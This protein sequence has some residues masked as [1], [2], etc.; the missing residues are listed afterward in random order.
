MEDHSRPIFEPR[1]EIV[2]R[3]SDGQEEV[4]F[5]DQTRAV[6]ALLRQASEELV[7]A[8]KPKKAQERPIQVPNIGNTAGTA[9]FL[10]AIA[11]GSYEKDVFPSPRS[12]FS[13]V[14]LD[15]SGNT[16]RLQSGIP[17]PRLGSESVIDT[18]R[19]VAG[20]PR[21]QDSFEMLSPR[22]AEIEMPPPNKVVRG[23]GG[24]RKKS[25]VIKEKSVPDDELAIVPVPS[26]AVN[27][28]SDTIDG[29]EN[30]N[31]SPRPSPFRDTKPIGDEDP[32]ANS[33]EHYKI[34]SASA[35][36]ARRAIS[37]TGPS[38]DI[39]RQRNTMS[40]RRRS[41]DK[42]GVEHHVRQGSHSRQLSNDSS[43]DPSKKF[44]PKSL[45]SFGDKSQASIRERASVLPSKEGQYRLIYVS[46]DRTALNKGPLYD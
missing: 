30:R 1:E 25:D 16:P 6:R 7:S 33:P 11:T 45:G 20:T 29:T 22:N 27:L 14:G 8:P 26:T 9:N 4:P 43:A 32:P 2:R 46:F 13:P 12:G 5:E 24:R 36:N 38:P 40:A 3:A 28:S 44:V 18:P 41:L 31:K 39:L 34:N 17:T 23:G 35:L 42:D 21:V 10:K 37:V 19:A 15:G